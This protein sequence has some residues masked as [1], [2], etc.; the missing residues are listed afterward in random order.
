[1][2]VLYCPPTTLPE[3]QP[4]TN[5]PNRSCSILS[6]QAKTPH[7]VERRDHSIARR[8]PIIMRQANLMLHTGSK[9]VSRGQ[10]ATVSTPS[11]TP[12]WHPIAHHDFL[13][14]VASTLSRAGM[15]IVHE[16]HGLSAD[17]NRYFGLLQI[18]NGSNPDDFSVV[19]GLRNSH[20]KKF[21]L[22]LVVGASVMV[23]D[24]LSF[25]GEIRIA[26]KHT[27]HVQRDLPHLIERAIGKLGDL[28]HTQERRFAAYKSH[29]INDH[30]AHDIIIRSLDAR[31]IVVTQ[32]PNVIEQW[33]RP[34][35]PEFR[36]RTAWSLFNAFSQTL[37]GRLDVLPARTTALHGIID[38]CCGLHLTKA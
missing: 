24:N 11:A 26:R 31:A 9:T 25:S 18:A 4:T 37:K 34:D 17:R 16:S 19:L 10:L 30:E 3:N 2:L 29:E 38:T 35:H 8:R 15:Q 1:M 5:C 32:I 20:D 33:R 14:G 21:P 28:R 7:C 13:D 36:E 6:T 27:I 23:C 12:S 22:G